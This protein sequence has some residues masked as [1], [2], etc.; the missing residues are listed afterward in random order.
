MVWHF[1]STAKRTIA[2][3]GVTEDIFIPTTAANNYQPEDLVTSEVRT[4]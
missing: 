1:G 3:K 4:P 2:R